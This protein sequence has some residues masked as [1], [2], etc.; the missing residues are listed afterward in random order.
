MMGNFSDT[1]HPKTDGNCY[2]GIRFVAHF[3]LHLKLVAQLLNLQ[4]CTGFNT[5]LSIFCVCAV[6]GKWTEQADTPATVFLFHLF[7]RPPQPLTPHPR[8]D[9][10]TISFH[11][12]HAFW[13]DNFW[14]TKK[15]LLRFH[16]FLWI[17][18][19]FF[20]F[21]ETTCRYIIDIFFIDLVLPSNFS[22][23]K[24]CPEDAGRLLV[25][26]SP[27]SKTH[28]KQ[29][30]LVFQKYF[31]FHRNR[32]KHSCNFFCLSKTKQL[33]IYLMLFHP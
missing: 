4:L 19:F 31:F 27:G 12:C 28:Q 16:L 9:Q 1:L 32:R 11:L 8:N 25:K 29:N 22:G 14:V 2:Q 5:A 23:L 3:K 15:L 18:F 21:E 24:F 20:F 26:W 6:V 33:V 30:F 10:N 7:I 13:T 17:F